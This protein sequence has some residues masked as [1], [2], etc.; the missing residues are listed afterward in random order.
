MPLKRS[1]GRLVRER[2][3][4][5]WYTLPADWI[6]NL[7]E[8]N[9]GYGSRELLEERG[10]AFAGWFEVNKLERD[11]K[12]YVVLMR[13]ANDQWAI[14]LEL[15]DDELGDVRALPPEEAWALARE[16]DAKAD[17]PIDVEA[18]LPPS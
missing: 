12:P 13:N 1:G 4:A 14:E 5:R 15:T 11:G 18:D 6:A 17:P 2:Y 8:R 3:D 16:G 10:G 9:R 7:R